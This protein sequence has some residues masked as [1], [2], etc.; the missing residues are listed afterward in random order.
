M[1]HCEARPYQTPEIMA[2]AHTRSRRE[3]QNQTPTNVPPN[4]AIASTRL[5]RKQV[6]SKYGRSMHFLTLEF[7]STSKDSKSKGDAGGGGL[8]GG[9][10]EDT[11]T[12]ADFA[13]D[14]LRRNKKFV[15]YGSRGL[16]WNRWG[17]FFGTSREDWMVCALA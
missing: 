3:T 1:W 12:E 13:E 10:M 16:L 8:I 15:E 11:V 4:Q 17:V 5:N 6:W 14:Y 9:D 7:E 2:Y